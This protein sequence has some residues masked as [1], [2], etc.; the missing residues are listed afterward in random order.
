MAEPMKYVVVP[1][2]LVKAL[3]DAETCLVMT[4]PHV[5]GDVADFIR[6]VQKQA[7]AALD[8]ASTTAS[9]DVL[10][11][12]RALTEVAIPSLKYCEDKYGHDD[13][14]RINCEVLLATV[15]D[16]ILEAARDG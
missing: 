13:M 12:V 2:A 15:P 7:D 4:R 11:V 8:N 10:A 1:V 14:A 16:D 9:F 3:E 6:G 5:G